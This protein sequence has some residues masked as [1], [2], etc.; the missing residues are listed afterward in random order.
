[1]IS[2][3][4]FVKYSLLQEILMGDIELCKGDF[5]DKAYQSFITE[6]DVVLVN[7]AM[8]IF[9]GRSQSPENMASLDDHIAGLFAK[10]KPGAQMVTFSS[11]PL[12][13]SLTDANNKR[14]IK[15]KPSDDDAS[16][17]ECRAVDLGNES[18]SWTNKNISVYIYRRVQNS[19]HFSVF[20]CD[21]CGFTCNVLCECTG[22]LIKTCVY[23]HSKRPVTGVRE[24]TKGVQYN[25]DVVEQRC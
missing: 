20:I 21:N 17:F 6:A 25:Q 10:M 11:L 4:I 1:M 2:Q 18:V 13:L 3:L 14:E 8:E 7:N 5:C 12:G 24:A 15:G 16:F 23:C 19:R 22:L 9:S